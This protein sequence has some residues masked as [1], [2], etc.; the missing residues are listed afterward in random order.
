[1]WPQNS[2]K[3]TYEE[4]ICYNNPYLIFYIWQ[5]WHFWYFDI[6]IFLIRC[7]QYPG[8][9]YMTQCL[10]VFCTHEDNGTKPFE[11]WLISFIAM[12]WYLKESSSLF[13]KDVKSK[14]NISDVKTFLIEHFLCICLGCSD[15]SKQGKVT[16]SCYS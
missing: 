1:M 3:K 5:F 16:Y 4:M 11:I 9:K 7:M 14:T 13:V 15:H 12:T 2:E 6:L 10:Y 8:L